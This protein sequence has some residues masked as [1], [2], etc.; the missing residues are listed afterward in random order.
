MPVKESL[1]RPH[2]IKDISSEHFKILRAR[3]YDTLDK[4]PR[5]IY[6]HNLLNTFFWLGLH[7]TFYLIILFLGNQKL[8]L[9]LG[10]IGLGFTTIGV[11][12]NLV[13]EAAHDT[14]FRNKTL[15]KAILYFLETMGTNN[16]L[17]KIRHIR[18]HHAYP[19]IPYW[20]CDVEQSDVLR[21]F[22]SAPKL[23]FQKYQHIY[24]PFLYPF[25]TFVW[26]WSR[27]FR[28]FFGQDR[29]VNRTV[30]LPRIEY[31]KL[32]FAKALHLTLFL[33]IPILL[34]ST[35][36]YWIVAAFV[37]FNFTASISG[38]VALLS[39]HVSDDMEFITTNE[40]GN[41]DRSW[42][43]H[44][45]ASTRDF[46]PE[47]KFVGFLYG[48]FNHHIAH[49]L[50]PNL[51]HS[52][53]PLITRVIKDFANEYGY[54]YQFYPTVGTSLKAHYRLLKNNAFQVNI[55]EETL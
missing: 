41:I 19:N 9:F 53:F 34:L 7:I 4:N 12:L 24:M 2:Y 42:L 38:M 40:R 52:Y 32:F 36:W 8:W 31:Y 10:Y 28:D 25:Y 18:L 30:D 6:L 3:V 26:L 49:H 43:Y 37:A 29:I 39:T 14:L 15:N 35:P 47:N 20:D 17:W 44:Q 21:L 54:P 48:G 23:S 16:H 33:V 55:F 22:P 46:A 5:N 13:H 1:H 27:D 51:H 11:F 45:M 50:F